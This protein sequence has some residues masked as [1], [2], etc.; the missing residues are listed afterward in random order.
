M[1]PYLTLSLTVTLA[2]NTLAIPVRAANKPRAGKPEGATVVWTN[3]DL[4][5]PRAKGLI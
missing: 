2:L 4:E 3:N 1:K 5:T